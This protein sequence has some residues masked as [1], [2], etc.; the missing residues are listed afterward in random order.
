MLLSLPFVIPVV[1]CPTVTVVNSDTSGVVGDF[2]SNHLV[3]C[4]SGYQWRSNGATQFTM[5]CKIPNNPDPSDGALGYWQ[6]ER[7][8]QSNR[9]DR[10][11]SLLSI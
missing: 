2:G 1:S 6:N 9:I 10:S 7:S 3:T 8:C 11:F 4:D 5:T